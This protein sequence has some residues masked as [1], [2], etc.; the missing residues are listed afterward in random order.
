MNY[1]PSLAKAIGGSWGFDSMLSAL[2]PVFYP[3]PF[4]TAAPRNVYTS[5]AG[6]AGV[7]VIVCDAKASASAAALQSA[8]LPARLPLTAHS[9]SFLSTRGL[10]IFKTK[11]IDIP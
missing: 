10:S 5:D 4:L 2:C 7:L 3:S 1:P 11:S 6:V 8:L 9:V